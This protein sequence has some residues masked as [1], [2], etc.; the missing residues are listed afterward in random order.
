MLAMNNYIF[1]LLNAPAGASPALVSV[2][3]LV[4]SKLVDLVPFLLA[5]LWVWG[6]PARRAGLA[7]SSIAA[8]FA[9][10]TNQLV[11]L[12]WYEPRPFMIGLGRTLMAH[13]PENSFPSDHA[14]FML[15]V[16]LALVGTRAAPMWGQ[17]VI[18]LGVLVAWARI[19]LGLHFPLDMLASALI[20][21][22]FGVLAATLVSDVR[23]W[24]M[25]AADRI[26][27]GALDALRLPSRVFPRRE[28]RG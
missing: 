23:R 14:T 28:D 8:A 4:A 13:A 16:G 7:A 17:L 19:Y 27:E 9:I 20:A 21:C 1:I 5:A 22:L 18:A 2:A 11:G 6:K 15:T 26:Y 10:G 12:F 24:I 3:E 25:P